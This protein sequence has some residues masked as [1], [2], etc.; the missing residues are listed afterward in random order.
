VKRGVAQHGGNRRR[1]RREFVIDGE[2]HA[3]ILAQFGFARKEP[4][5]RG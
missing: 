1:W 4:T 3:P 5:K 2:V